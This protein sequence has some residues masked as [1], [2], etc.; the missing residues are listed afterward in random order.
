M[1]ASLPMYDFEEC[2]IHTDSMWAAVANECNQR[3]FKAPATLSGNS[4]ESG[5]MFM[6]QTCGLPLVSIL[7]KKMT[8]ALE[9]MDYKVFKEIQE[10][11]EQLDYKV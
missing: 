7:R 10:R 1:V 5:T 8:D 4:C 11:L 9:Q 6:T 2:R 3:G